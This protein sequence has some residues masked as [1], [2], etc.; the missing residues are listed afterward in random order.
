MK[1]MNRFQLIVVLIVNLM[2]LATTVSS[3]HGEENKPTPL[4]K[5][6]IQQFGERMY[7][8]G[9]LPSGAPM[10][11]F[12]SRDVPVEG[13]SFT[14]VSC[15]LR[16][17]LGSIE[18]TVVTPPTDGKSLYKSRELFKKGFE[19]V[20]AVRR[21]ALALAPRPAYT[22]ESLAACL[23]DG[24]DAGA[25]TMNP[26]MPLYKL[27]K[28]E[29]DIL[30]RYLKSLSADLPP[31]V[32]DST[33]SF[34]TVITD[35]VRKE[36][37]DAMLAGIEFYIRQKNG[38]ANAYKKNP[39]TTKMA[40]NM[41]GPDLLRK[42]LILSKW[43]LRGAPETWG[44]QLEEYYKK[45]PV[46]ALLGGITGGDWQP[47]HTFC[48]THRIPA[49]F[50]V[51]DYPV[52]S[53]TDW[54]TIYFS[55]GIYQEGEAAARY[56]NSLGELVKGKRIVEIVRR[57]KKGDALAAGFNKTWLNLGNSAVHIMTLSEKEPLTPE[58]LAGVMK[59]ENPAV[60]VIWDGSDALPAIESLAAA[61][62]RPGVLLL[63]SGYLGDSI[64][65]LKD[66][67]RE[68]T[69]FTYPYRL[70]QDDI[71]FDT[72]IK[73]LVKTAALDSSSKRILRQSYALSQVESQALMDLR[74][75]Y[76]RDFLL[77]AIGMMPDM[78]FPLYERL[79][80]GPGQRYASK[81]C[82][83]V[84]LGK[85]EKAELVRRSDWVIH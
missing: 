26:I 50:P 76:Y 52:I 35:D 80:F 34:A 60:L 75:E 24:V 82:Y 41:M 71:R 33:I 8:D 22:D 81:G 44:S 20:P 51:T 67:A 56:L 6:Q 68:Y 49:L 73:P 30:I 55:K 40:L 16:S 18:G 74:G 61:E 78:E 46:F 3:S 77:D 23:T 45:E 59:T 15:H 70:P 69:F 83:I 64:W 62:T 17:G 72:F 57:S 48:E 42:K 58:Y 13:T 4:S 12:V 5:E 39:R 43:Y 38:L 9:I 19:Q 32:T 29:M 36:D 7:R 31:G 27:E 85:G 10:K 1:T 11:A 37:S 66:N 47:I 25:R 21:Y 63:S 79:S 65:N 2:L 53:D 28:R 14:C 84:Q 54:Y